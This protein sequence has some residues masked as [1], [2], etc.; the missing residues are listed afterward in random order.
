MNPFRVRLIGPGGAGKSTVGR[1]LA[2][3]LEAPF[4]DL[5]ADMSGGTPVVSLVLLLTA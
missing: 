3:R 4:L 1:I 5:V 2:E